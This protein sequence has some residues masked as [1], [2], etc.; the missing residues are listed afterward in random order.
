VIAHEGVVER[1]S[2]SGLHPVSLKKQGR[3][4]TARLKRQFVQSAELQERIKRNLAGVGYMMEE[5]R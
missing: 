5:L 2:D 4:D 1:E 3:S